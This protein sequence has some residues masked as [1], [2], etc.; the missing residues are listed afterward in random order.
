VLSLGVLPEIIDSEVIRHYRYSLPDCKDVS[1]VIWVTGES[2]A[3]QCPAVG[4]TCW[5]CALEAKGEE[6][7]FPK[8][9]ASAS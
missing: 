2:T 5:Q 8:V 9:Q 3:S 7:S 6:A 1:L 4:E